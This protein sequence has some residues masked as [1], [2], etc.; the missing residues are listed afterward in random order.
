MLRRCFKFNTDYGAVSN[1]SRTS[2][3]VLLKANLGLR[4]RYNSH[5]P[6]IYSVSF[7]S[8][9]LSHLQFE[10]TFSWSQ[11]Y[12]LPIKFHFIFSQKST[13]YWAKAICRLHG[14]KR[15]ALFVIQAQAILT[16]SPPAA[17]DEGGGICRS[18][19]P[20]WSGPSISFGWRP[21]RKSKLVRVIRLRIVCNEEKFIRTV[22]HCC[23]Q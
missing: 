9:N 22:T 18:A 23:P 11:K 3:H 12:R 6:T 14:V 20:T 21:R 17:N 19:F 15:D 10:I 1:I 4:K 5:L 8:Q 2:R 16:L 13:D 7:N